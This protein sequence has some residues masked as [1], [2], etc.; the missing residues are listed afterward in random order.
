M[1]HVLAHSGI[2]QTV[3]THTEIP[4]TKPHTEALTSSDFAFLGFGTLLV[5]LVLKWLFLLGRL[6]RIRSSR[7]TVSLSGSHSL[8]CG[9]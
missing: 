8:P 3:S 1:N 2:Q 4:P 5:V 6:R 9:W 7:R